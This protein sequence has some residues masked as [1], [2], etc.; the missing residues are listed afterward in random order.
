MFVSAE[1]AKI[2]ILELLEEAKAKAGSQ[3]AFSRASGLNNA[4]VWRASQKRGS[5]SAK[6]LLTTIA[7]VGAEKSVDIINETL[8][9]AQN[10]GNG[11]VGEYLENFEKAQEI[12]KK[13][14]KNRKSA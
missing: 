8:A 12:Q 13:K 1:T 9:S 10:Q 14:I 4:T 7:Y 11:T 6:A 2:V 5:F 3:N